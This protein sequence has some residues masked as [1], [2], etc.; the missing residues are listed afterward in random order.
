MTA[1]AGREGELKQAFGEYQPQERSLEPYGK[2]QDIPDGEQL[3]ARATVDWD[4]AREDLDQVQQRKET[5]SGELTAIERLM[6]DFAAVRE[7]LS[8]IVSPAPE[9]EA[10]LFQET[11]DVARARRNEVR[12]TLS[13]AVRLPFDRLRAIIADGGWTFACGEFMEF[14]GHH[15]DTE[16]TVRLVRDQG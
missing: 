13:E 15:N 6:A 5:L 11:V 14:E 2:P 10:D 4:K 3:I 9:R 1:A 12:E 7:S 8:V 16:I